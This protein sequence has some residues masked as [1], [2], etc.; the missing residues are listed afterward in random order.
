MGLRLGSGLLLH[1]GLC[2]VNQTDF[3]NSRDVDRVAIES[4]R[5]SG[6]RRRRVTAKMLSTRATLE[7]CHCIQQ[8]RRSRRPENRSDS[9]PNAKTAC[10]T[11][12]DLP[13]KSTRSSTTHLL[14][15]PRR[16]TPNV[17]LELQAGAR[18][19]RGNQPAKSPDCC[20]K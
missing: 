17:P 8:R 19:P 16:V 13:S 20:S 11:C 1:S 3:D 5:S 6:Q 10:T 12:R 15:A 7:L 2:A 9:P 14:L 18:I 4:A